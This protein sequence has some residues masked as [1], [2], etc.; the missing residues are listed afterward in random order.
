MELPTVKSI[1]LELLLATFLSSEK[2]VLSAVFIIAHDQYNPPSH[3]I[4]RLPSSLT[5]V[6]VLL[7]SEADPTIADNQLQNNAL[8]ER[9]LTIKTILPT[10]T[11]GRKL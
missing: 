7:S 8:T 11:G 4:D 5:I 3:I 6:T 1:Q 10:L 2:Q 9:Y